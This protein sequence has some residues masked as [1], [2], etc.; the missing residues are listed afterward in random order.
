M[1]MWKTMLR[2]LIESRIPEEAAAHSFDDFHA[3]GLAYVNLVRTRGL[4]A[5][6]YIAEAGT[7]QHNADDYLVNPH[8]HAYRFRTFAVSGWAQNITFELNPIGEPYHRFRF[9]SALRGHPSIEHDRPVRLYRRA[10]QTIRPDGND[11]YYLDEHEIHTI[12][13]ARDET[14]ILFLLQYVDQRAET[15]L[16][17]RES[18]PPSLTDLYRPMMWDNVQK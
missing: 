11:R 8:D 4:T 18:D 17:M 15:A 6:L 12:R 14:T 2:N 9:Q 5:K 16:Y 3:P 7:V 10:L 13:I 1:T